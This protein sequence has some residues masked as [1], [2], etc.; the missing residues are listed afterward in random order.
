M[1]YKFR[2]TKEFVD[3]WNIECDLGECPYV[4]GDIL[5]IMKVFNDSGIPNCGIRKIK[6]GTHHF[7]H[8]KILPLLEFIDD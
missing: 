8:Y 5:T 3:H 2:I 7:D 6:E 4:V 1:N